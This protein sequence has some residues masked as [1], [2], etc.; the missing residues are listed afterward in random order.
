MGHKYSA[1]L[2]LK[3]AAEVYGWY[4][5]RPGSFTLF[6]HQE[7]SK[8]MV[9]YNTAL[10]SVAGLLF[11]IVPKSRWGDFLPSERERL[12]PLCYLLL[13]IISISRGLEQTQLFSHWKAS[14]GYLQHEHVPEALQ[15]VH[16]EKKKKKKGISFLWGTTAV[17]DFG[18]LLWGIWAQ[19][20][21]SQQEPE[22]VT[23]QLPSKVIF[24]KF[25][26]EKLQ[27]KWTR[28]IS[29]CSQCPCH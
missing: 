20:N 16:T 9:R 2:K 3:P 14:L 8:M 5:L 15:Q 19:K 6:F 28:S 22:Q 1:I 26:Q 23:F 24:L 4:C 7:I 29:N 11:Y 12:V 18:S 17:K 13:C 21:L 27:K 25:A 10:V